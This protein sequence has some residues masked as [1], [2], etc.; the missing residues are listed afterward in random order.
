MRDLPVEDRGDAVFVGKVVAGTE[1]TVHEAWRRRHRWLSAFEPGQRQLEYRMRLAR[2]VERTAHG[3]DH[4][5]GGAD[6]QPRQRAE[7]HG[8]Q[9]G[10]DGAELARDALARLLEARS[11]QQ[12][13]GD[14]CATDAL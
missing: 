14:R 8:M 1:V 3:G 5:L 2:G 6:I 4:A 9:L 11:A 7:R 12:L 13:A 10:Q